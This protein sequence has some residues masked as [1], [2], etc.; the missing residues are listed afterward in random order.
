MNEKSFEIYDASFCPNL[1][2]RLIP[3][4]RWPEISRTVRMSNVSREMVR[5]VLIMNDAPLM[6]VLACFLLNRM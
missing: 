1:A 3:A 4:S 2:V 5:A 6:S